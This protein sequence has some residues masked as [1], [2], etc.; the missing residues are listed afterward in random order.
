MPG[1]RNHTHI[2]CNKVAGTTA[3]NIWRNECDPCEEC[4]EQIPN[5][6]HWYRYNH[7]YQK[8]N[9]NWYSGA[10]ILTNIGDGGN[11]KGWWDQIT[12]T[13][14]LTAGTS[15]DQPKFNDSDNSLYFKSAVKYMDF[16]SAVAF[17]QNSDWICLNL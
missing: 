12:D 9:G 1:S 11:I 13:N 5:I 10:D 6:R 14:H 16:T 8:A 4:V 15:N 2:N 17:T 7:G 3:F